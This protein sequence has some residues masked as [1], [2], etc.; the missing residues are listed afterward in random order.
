MYNRPTNTVINT[1]SGTSTIQD[2]SMLT[3]MTL[4]TRIVGSYVANNRADFGLGW[5]QAPTGFPDNNSDNFQFY[6]NGSKIE[7]GS[8]VG[9]Y[10]G[11]TGSTL[12]IDP[13]ALE[14]SLEFGDNIVSIGKYS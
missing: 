5:A 1:F 13:I 2:V 7:S 10:N 14:Y 9:F 11:V 8:I 12:I 6:V 3:Y 4:N